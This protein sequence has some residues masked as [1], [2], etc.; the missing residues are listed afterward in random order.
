MPHLRQTQND[1]PT[2]VVIAGSALLLTPI[3]GSLFHCGCD[4]PWR[5]FA[6]HCNVF[7]ATA[8]W[9][10]PWCQHAVSSG[11]ALGLSVVAGIASGRGLMTP[12]G[13]GRTAMHVGIASL[14]GFAVSLIG[15]L[16]TGA[17][18]LQLTRDALPAL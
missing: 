15:F 1:G 17:A 2:I 18:S 3:C 11:L 4:W 5:G 7:V 13:Q 8:T 16:L 10:C 6:F 12:L 14:L 9:H